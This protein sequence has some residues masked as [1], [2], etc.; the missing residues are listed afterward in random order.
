MSRRRREPRRRTSQVLE[1]SS[2]L[3]DDIKQNHTKNTRTLN[4]KKQKR[5]LC[6]SDNEQ[7]DEEKKTEEKIKPRSW[8]DEQKR[9]S[10]DARDLAHGRRPD[11]ASEDTV[12]V[13]IAKEDYNDR[14]E[15]QQQENEKTLY[16]QKKNM[17]EEHMDDT[18]AFKK[19][20]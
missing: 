1:R 6:T 9:N 4:A 5:T 19:Q 13:D 14:N 3:R 7:N 18:S 15:T 20:I 8:R 12:E 17:T 2:H 10:V 16:G 11:H